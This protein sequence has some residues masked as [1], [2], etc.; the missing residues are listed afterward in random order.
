MV[1]GLASGTV[2]A[3]VVP[4]LARVQALISG[5]HLVGLALCVGR[6]PGHAHPVNADSA[7]A[8]SV[9]AGANAGALPVLAHFV[10]QA[11][12][13]GRAF[14]HA[15]PCVAHDAWATALCAGPALL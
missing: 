15:K 5:A 4:V 8:T 11:V 3:R 9:V 1:D 7:L 10:R 12:G 6:A 14:G 2:T 13:S